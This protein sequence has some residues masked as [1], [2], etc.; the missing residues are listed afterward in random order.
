MTCREFADFFGAYLA[1][2]LPEPVRQ[3]FDD[4]LSVCVNC[5]RY[6]A[7]YHATISCGGVAFSDLESL[8]PEDVPEDL[9]AAILSTRV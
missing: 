5:K 1:S 2:E 6:L 9:I 4:H 3:S 7:H 8:V